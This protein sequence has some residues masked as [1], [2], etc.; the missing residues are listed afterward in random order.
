MRR[1]PCTLAMAVM[2]FASSLALP[3]FATNEPTDYLSSTMELNSIVEESFPEELIRFRLLL[4]SS[5]ITAIYDKDVESYL[6]RYLTYGAKDTEKILGRSEVVFPIFE[7][8]LATYGLPSQLKFLPIIESSLVPEAVSTKGAAGLWQF[9]PTTAR[10]LGLT[11]NQYIDERRDLYKSTETAV[12][13]LQ[14]LYN[15]FGNW[16]LA[17]AAYNCGSTRIR[18]AINQAGSTDFQKIK[19]FL[20]LQTQRYLARFLAASYTATYY[21]QHGLT[22]ATT[23][24]SDMDLMALRLSEAINLNKFSKITGL[25]IAILKKLN[26]AFKGGYIPATEGG[27]FMIL[28]KKAWYVYLEATRTQ[29]KIVRP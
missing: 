22:P 3:S 6:R 9:M 15:R 13:Y 20:P 27:V 29:K 21:N 19:S 14:Q 24:L 2:L 5:P 18:Q 7:H 8:Y 12:K 16:E 4:M 17:L 23:E 11:I 28:P 26:P 10:H 1:I 25:D